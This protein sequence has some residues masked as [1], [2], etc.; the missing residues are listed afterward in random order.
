MAE[1]SALNVS[2]L[3]DKLLISPVTVRN[4]VTSVLTKLQVTNRRQ[5]MLLA[6][7]P[8]PR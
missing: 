7:D 1:R 4:H 5:A 3:S 2:R 8:V 6:R